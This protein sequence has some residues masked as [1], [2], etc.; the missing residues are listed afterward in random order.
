MSPPHLGGD[1]TEGSDDIPARMFH[2]PSSQGGDTGSNPVRAT[3]RVGLTNPQILDNLKTVRRVVSVSLSPLGVTIDLAT[4]DQS[5]RFLRC[6]VIAPVQ[7]PSIGRSD[8][9]SLRQIHLL[10]VANHAVLH[11][12]LGLAGGFASAL[13]VSIV[14]QVMSLVE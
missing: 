12:H 14:M 8:S 2:A 6:S 7:R 3:L 5:S 4:F 1:L 11:I 9:T 13:L 10:R